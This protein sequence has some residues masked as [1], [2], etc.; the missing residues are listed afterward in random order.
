MTILIPVSHT[1]NEVVPCSYC[2]QLRRTFILIAFSAVLPMLFFTSLLLTVAVGNVNRPV[3]SSIPWIIEF[4]FVILYL[5]LTLAISVL[6]FSFVKRKSPLVKYHIWYLYF[7]VLIMLLFIGACL[8][9][10][11]INS[12]YWLELIVLCCGVGY[13]YAIYRYL[14]LDSTTWTIL[15]RTH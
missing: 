5:Q 9:L 10:T 11:A 7:H 2:L 8:A 4:V 12:N 13:F 3:N 6:I 1:G 14:K 15:R